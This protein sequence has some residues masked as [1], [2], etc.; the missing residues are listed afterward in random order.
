MLFF[1]FLY[2][3]QIEN[4]YKFGVNILALKECQQLQWLFQILG[5]HQMNQGNFF[6][7]QEL[8]QHAHD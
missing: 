4:A 7:A 1:A 6:K 3:N 2:N 8:L 5:I